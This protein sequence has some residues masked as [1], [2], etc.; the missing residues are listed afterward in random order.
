M[1]DDT[2]RIATGVE[3]RR[4]LLV[5]AACDC[6]LIEALDESGTPEAIAARVGLDPRAARILCR[7]LAECGVATAG[8]D[9]ACGLTDLGAD[10]RDQTRR[11]RG[12]GHELH[13]LGN[14]A[15]LPFIAR[16]GTPARGERTPDDVG[17]FMKAM[18]SRPPRSV[19]RVAEVLCEVAGTGR[20]VDLGGG[21]GL[22]SRALIERGWTATVVDTAKTIAHVAESYGLAEVDG[23]TLF[24]GDFH[25]ALP[26]GDFDAAL[27]ANI[28]H[29]YSDTENAALVARLAGRYPSLRAVAILDFVDGVSTGARL[30][31]VNMLVHTE[32]GDT[33]DLA[34]MTRW[35][36][37]AGLAD[38]S[39]HDIYEQHH[40]VI[41]RRQ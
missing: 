13:L 28:C 29:I 20:I 21:P 39:I 27:M 15:Q 31:A 2:P 22:Y 36:S 40:L 38:V 35:L 33:Y 3:T 26:D 34:A 30:F 19:D 25:E 11:G 32:R 7:A 5:A 1:T 16:E 24:S 18:A 17:R 8:E 23:L 9:G 4:F 6:G 41:G 37:G 10:F 14:W 12:W